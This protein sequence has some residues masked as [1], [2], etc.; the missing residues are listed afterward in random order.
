MVWFSFR[1]MRVLLALFSSLLMATKLVVSVERMP[2]ALF[3]SLRAAEHPAPF[4]AVITWALEVTE[5]LV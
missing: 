3:K 5:V 4:P 1:L 2:L